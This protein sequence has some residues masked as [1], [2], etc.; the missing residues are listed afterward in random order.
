VTI[1]DF[2]PT[3]DGEGRLAVLDVAAKGDEAGIGFRESAG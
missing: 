1:T 2:L 3:L